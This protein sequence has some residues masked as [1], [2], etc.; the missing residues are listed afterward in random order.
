[1]WH[2]LTR[3][4]PARIGA[5]CLLAL[6]SITAAV[7]AEEPAPPITIEAD[8]AVLKEKH[9]MSIYRGNVVLKQGNMQFSADE[10]KVESKD[11]KLDTMTAT[12]NPVNFTQQQKDKK[13]ITAQAQS[14]QYFASSQMIVLTEKANLTQGNSQFT[15]NRIEYRVKT[16]TVFA[17]SNTGTPTRVKITI[18]QDPKE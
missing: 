7:S 10:I 17:G 9:G 16:D 13:A 12:G 8:Q 1:M 3:L 4:Y 11:G 18:N 5:T 15:G 2:L 6:A 14:I